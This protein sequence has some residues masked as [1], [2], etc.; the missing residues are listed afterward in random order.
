MDRILLEGM[1]FI[2]RHGVLPEER[3]LGVR[4]V[5]DVELDCDLGPASASD[6]LVDTVDY[7]EVYELVRNVVEGESHQLLE[8]VAGRIADTMLEL[9]RVAA[10]TVRVRKRPPLAGE[11]RSFGVE[12]TRRR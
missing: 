4:L 6:R 5:V 9:D 12:M 1:A 3:R 7:P 10:A 2:G 11:F 8:T